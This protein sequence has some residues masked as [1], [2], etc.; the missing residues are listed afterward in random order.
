MVRCLG[1]GADVAGTATRRTTAARIDSIFR[2]V[3]HRSACGREGA[4]PAFVS[5]QREASRT[6]ARAG[7]HTC[8]SIWRG[9]DWLSK[10][11]PRPIRFAL[12]IDVQH[13]PRDL[14]PVGPFCIR[15]EHAHVGDGMLF[16]IDGEPV[17]GG[18]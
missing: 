13:D 11:L 8:S 9:Q 12:W 17:I 4:E 15:I 3:S 2:L 1:M 14:A 16:V 18:C 5:H 10:A 6:G 7:S